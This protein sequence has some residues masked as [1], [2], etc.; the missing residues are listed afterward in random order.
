LDVSVVRRVREI[1]QAMR[2]A[3]FAVRP[4]R[5]Y[6]F[7]GEAIARPFGESAGR[8]AVRAGGVT[9][10]ED[11]FREALR[12]DR[13]RLPNAKFNAASTDSCGEVGPPHGRTGG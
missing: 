7:V 5:R 4:K 9:D 6:D 11:E 3:T 2:S 1:F 12:R 8:G 10:D 13:A